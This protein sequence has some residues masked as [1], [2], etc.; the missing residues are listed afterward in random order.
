MNRILASV[1]TLEQHIDAVN[2]HPDIYRPLRCPHCE[3]GR[4]WGH[5]CY[6][7]KA[8]R[9][10]VAPQAS[11]NPVPIL[12]YLCPTCKHTCSRL[13]ACIAP[14]RWFDW[15][16]QTLVLLLI[17]AGSSVRHCSQCSERARSTVRRWRDWLNDRGNTFTFW[18]QSRFPEL[19]RHPDQP[20]L[21]RDVLQNMTLM[22]A[23]ACCDA[24]MDVP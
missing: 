24:H 22:Q 17:L 16:M 10:A 2:T 15:A 21:W 12:R 14:R 23:M 19:G 4:L 9:R 5:G 13:P 7:R 3:A 18:L 8:D 6:Y 1:T 20:S 11:H